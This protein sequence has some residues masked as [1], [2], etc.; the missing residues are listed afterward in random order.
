MDAHPYINLRQQIRRCSKQFRHN[1]DA[2]PSVFQPAKG[3]TYGYDMAMVEAA[4]N[5]YEATLPT[6]FLAVQ[7]APTMEAKLL[8]IASVLAETNE[9]MEV[10][11]FA[12]EVLAYLVIHEGQKAPKRK[13]FVL[14]ARTDCQPL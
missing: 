5:E 1:D 4:L 9:S 13:P 12:R 14:A 7:P 8:H 10:R 3:F 2:S 6:E 11:D